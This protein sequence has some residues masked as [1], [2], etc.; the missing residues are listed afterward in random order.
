MLMLRAAPA[1]AQQVPPTCAEFCSHSGQASVASLCGVGQGE[2]ASGRRRRCG[3]GAERGGRRSVAPKRGAG[4][5]AAPAGP[6]QL[7]PRLR[8]LRIVDYRLPA[9]PG[10]LARRWRPISEFHHSFNAWRSFPGAAGQGVNDK[11]ES[12]AHK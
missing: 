8:L 12:G 6:A 9:S 1:P 7:R 4:C 11:G 2:V 3:G 10:E 5:S